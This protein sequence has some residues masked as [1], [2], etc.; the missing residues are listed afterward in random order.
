MN[1]GTLNNIGF[2]KQIAAH[3]TNTARAQSAAED[4]SEEYGFDIP[5]YDKPTS[6]QTESNVSS[7][8]WT[9]DSLYIND[10]NSPK[11]YT[12]NMSAHNKV[13]EKLKSEGINP[14]SRTPAHEITDEQMA[15]LGERY[16]LSRFGNCSI[17]DPEFGNF[18]L[19]LTYLNVFSFDEIEDFYGVLPF[20]ANN[21]AIVYYRDPNTG[22]WAGYVNPDGSISETWDEYLA[23]INKEYF[24]AQNPDKTESECERMTEEFINQRTER[25]SILGSLF[26]HIAENIANSLEVTKPFIEDVS[27]K[28]KEDFGGLM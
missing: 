3:G 17:E 13:R 6:E 14:Y 24:K 18:M 1:I 28:L 16:D 8:R 12:V 27:E 4:L 11:G 26:S 2:I 10:M 25:F 22:E 21:K 9:S 19:D 7:E 20:N 5:Q 23:C 15:W